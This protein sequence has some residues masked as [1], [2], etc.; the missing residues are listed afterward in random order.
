M[1]NYVFNYLGLELW[2]ISHKNVAQV[3][4]IRV[5]PLSQTP[6]SATAILINQNLWRSTLS[7]RIGKVV[8]SHAEVARSIP[9][10]AETAPIYTLQDSLKRYCPWRWRVRPVN[11]YLPSLAPLSVA[12][13][14]LLQLGFPHW[15]TSVDYCK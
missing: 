14:C 8:V 1:N 10:W 6:S 11:F 3:T 12:G 2:A 15:A 13:C 7:D 9:G 5:V 4:L